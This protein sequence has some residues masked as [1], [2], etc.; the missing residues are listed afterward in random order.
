MWKEQRNGKWRYFERYED[1]LTGKQRKVS[2]TLD[3][4]SD[5]KAGQ[6]LNALIEEKMR[7]TSEDYM[8]KDVVTL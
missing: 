7:N 1:P 5:K 2:V 8:I 6:M 4:K 3:R